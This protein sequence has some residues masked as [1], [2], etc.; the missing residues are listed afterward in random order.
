MKHERWNQI[1][2]ICHEALSREGKERTDYIENACAGDKEFLGEIKSLLQQHDDN[3][4][5]DPLVQFQSSFVFSDDRSLSDQAIGPYRLIKTIDTGGMGQ[6]YLAVRNDEQFERFVALK[7]IRKGA[8]S[9]DVLERFYSER[10][11][12]ASLNHPNIARLFDGGETE[13]G[14]PWFA[15]EYIEGRPITEY[16]KQHCSTLEETLNLFLKVC[17]A[18]Q[19]AHQNLIIHRD[20]KPAN[21]LITPEGMPKLLDFGIAKLTDINL[22]PNQT[23]YQN[24]LMT[25]EYASPEQVQNKPVSTASDVYALGVLLYELL[26]GMLPYQFD[27]RTPAAIEKTVCNTIPKLPSTV[28]DLKK[29]KGDLDSVV[30]KALRK[31]PANR[32][33]SVEQLVNDLEKYQLNLPVLAQ[34]NTSAY[35]AGKFLA[36][37]KWGSAVVVAVTLLVIVFTGV[38]FMQSKAIKE[39][40][41]EAERQRD[42]AEGVSTF[43]TGL[44]ES[45]DP[46]KAEDVSLTAIELLGRGAGRIE[47]ELN[48][49]ADLQADLYLVISDV[50]DKLGMYDK[51]LDM[52]N[53]AYH[54]LRKH[55]AKNNAVVAKSINYR[56]WLNYR[57][58]HFRKAD[59][60]LTAA[61]AM[62]REL[63]GNMNLDLSRSLNDL[64]VLKER[65]GDFEA[66]DSII[67]EAL[68]IRRA[69]LGD[70]H[71]SIAVSLHNYATLKYKMGDI[72]TAAEMEQ[73]VVEIFVETEGEYHLKTANAITTLGTFNMVMH[74][75]EEAERLYKR[76]LKIRFRLYGKENVNV[77][78]SYGMLGNLLR[79]QGKY[80]EAEESLLKGLDMRIRLLGEDNTQVAGSYTMLGNLYIAT[81]Q[82]K[83]AGNYFNDALSIYYGKLPAV[84]YLIANQL[85]ALGIT[86]MKMKDFTKAAQYF[87]EAKIMRDK[88]FGHE[89]LKTITSTIKLGES[90]AALGKFDEAKPLLTAGLAA[91]EKSGI[92]A[93]EL[94]KL[95]ENVL[96]EE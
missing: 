83:K 70:N 34:K 38:T 75:L 19:N 31:N 89:H 82:Y 51:G 17:K 63:F 54:L 71:K 80:K 50:Y 45:V 36:R 8:V 3:R 78:R 65:I 47:T 20:L 40:A 15:M 7:I 22:Q 32:Y 5:R 26:T 68:K 24:R 33:P 39:R 64:Y 93:V 13:D 12:L 30:M 21:I 29:L 16:C 48:G 1:E 14:A 66:A 86:G 85:H 10:Q 28:S 49:Q 88:I 37:H 74:S 4:L 25:P 23:Q 53:K 55:Y 6:V 11:I 69:L 60:L 73:K 9:D 91:L 72:K 2:V 41:L 42:R 58:E 59:S 84:H 46:S 76:A 94:K 87:R 95:A 44:F 79:I 77:A 67:W 90:L 61:V 92:E 52:A 56:G 62:R 27:E 35:R 18:V 43:L 81:G 96:A 57:L